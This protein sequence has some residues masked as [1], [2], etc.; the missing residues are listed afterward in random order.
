MEKTKTLVIASG[1]FNP[2]H[3]GHIEYLTRSKELGDK[4]FVI[5]NNDIQ[6]QM[7]GSKQFMNEDERKLVIETLKPVDWAIVAIETESRLVDKSIKLIHEL[8]KDEFDNFIFSNGGDQTE[9][10]IAEGDICRN[11]GIKMVFGLG[12]KIQSSSWLLKD[13]K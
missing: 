3:K 12:D 8:Y 10:T 6:R 13:K 7:K 9:Y 4:L 2:V 5:V 1:Y 11:L